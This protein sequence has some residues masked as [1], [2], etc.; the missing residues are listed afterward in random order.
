MFCLTG[1]RCAGTYGHRLL[2]VDQGFTY[3]ILEA[4]RSRDMSL[5]QGWIRISGQPTMSNAEVEHMMD[6][7]ELTAMHFR[8]WGVDYCYDT[9]SNGYVYSP[10]VTTLHGKKIS[11]PFVT[12]PFSKLA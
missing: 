6:A 4:I 9:V 11:L 1:M 12:R 8:K 10:V 5:E 3:A 2:Q 7:I